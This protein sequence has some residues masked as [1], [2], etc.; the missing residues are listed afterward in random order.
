MIDEMCALHSNGAWE[1]VPLLPRKSVIGCQW[2]YT[3][4]VSLD[5]TIGRFMAH[6]VAKGYTQVYGHDYTD[7]FSPVDKMAFVR[8]AVGLSPSLI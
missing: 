8:L 5:G 2:L 4:K 1:L 7:T 3:F 6:Q